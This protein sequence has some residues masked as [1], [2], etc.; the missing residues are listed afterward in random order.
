MSTGHLE[1]PAAA[2]TP[3][4]RHRLREL[5]QRLGISLGAIA[6]KLNISIE[7]VLEQEDP[8][9]D[10]SISQLLN[11]SRALGVPVDQLLVEVGNSLFTPT[12]T[13]A[14]ISKMLKI[15]EKI[16]DETKDHQ[17]KSFAERLCQQ[18]S[19]LMG[20]ETSDERSSKL[21]VDFVDQPDH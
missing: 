8:S 6:A 3:L 4:F 20:P 19:E 10:I 14:N 18:L 5:R 11:W 1:P 21:S 15:A 12:M 9:S 7:E 16:V 17:S 2:V 13:T